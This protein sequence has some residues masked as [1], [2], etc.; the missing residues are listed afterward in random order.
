MEKYSV[1]RDGSLYDR[2][3]ALSPDGEYLKG[4]PTLAHVL[5]A[6]WLHGEANGC[7]HQVI[8]YVAGG[9]DAD[10]DSDR[11]ARVMKSDRE[12]FGGAA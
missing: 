1:V 12:M 6:I 7:R 4:G 11:A 9:T 2:Y 5:P 3:V 10:L 8:R